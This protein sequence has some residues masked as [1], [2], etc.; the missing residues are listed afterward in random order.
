MGKEQSGRPG[1]GLTTLQIPMLLCFWK[2]LVA[3]FFLHAA[4]WLA[5]SCVCNFEDVS[6]EVLQVL[7][8]YI[9]RFRHGDDTCIRGISK[10]QLARILAPFVSSQPSR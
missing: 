8:I 9:L 2:G 5:Y 4:A 6:D 1:A 7:L 10:E 3:L